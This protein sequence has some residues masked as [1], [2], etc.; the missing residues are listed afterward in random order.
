MEAHLAGVCRRKMH[1]ELFGES[2]PQSL[3]FENS[4]CDVCSLNQQQTMQ[5]FNEEIKILGDALHQIGQKGEL[6]VAE[7]IRGSTVSWTNAYNK[8]AHSYGNH[9]GHSLEQWWLF[10]RQCHVLGLIKYELKSMIKGNGHY[11]VMGVYH[12]LQKSEQYIKN[13]KRLMLPSMKHHIDSSSTAVTNENS[14]SIPEQS[15]STKR[16]RIGKGSNILTVVRKMLADQENWKT[17]SDKQDYHFLGAFPKSTKQQLYYI[18]DCT[19][20]QQASPSNH[21]LW[22]DI[23]LS[24]G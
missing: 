5:S 17:V 19:S 18:P 3:N 9:R 23:Q 24:K 4:C 21:F 10:M 20:L 6:K 13:E 16:K 11:S 15:T 2:D 12:P 14:S 1:L 7:W 8:K 22:N